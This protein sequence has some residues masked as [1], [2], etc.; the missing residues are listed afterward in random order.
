MLLAKRW[1]QS[2]QSSSR[3][4]IRLRASFSSKQLFPRGNAPG[5]GGGLDTS[6]IAR[7]FGLEA[8]RGG[9]GE[10]GTSAVISPVANAIFAAAGKQIRKVPVRSQSNRPRASSILR[11]HAPQFKCRQSNQHFIG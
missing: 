9:V 6:L 5:D 10:P 11:T 7:A 2:T 3:V 8:A 4:S 1:R